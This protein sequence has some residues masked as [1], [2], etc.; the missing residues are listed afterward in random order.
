MAK[1]VI[2]C[3]SETICEKACNIEEEWGLSKAE[4]KNLKQVV[5][6]VER[7]MNLQKLA[8]DHI[9]ETLLLQFHVVNTQG[10]VIDEKGQIISFE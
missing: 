4:V 9:Y 8:M 10:A 2:N 6:N 5:S 3:L 1:S 7:N